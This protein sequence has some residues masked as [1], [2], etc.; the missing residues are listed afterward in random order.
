M[1]LA[2]GTARPN[3]PVSVPVV[4]TVKADVEVDMSDNWQES[5]DRMEESERRYRDI[6]EHRQLEAESLVE[7]A[8][9][10]TA[11]TD[12]E[13]MREALE[14]LRTIAQRADSIEEL[15]LRG[16][17]FSLNHLAAVRPAITKLEERLLKE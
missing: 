2:A 8:R 15:G 11:M 16:G 9:E 1:A 6:G 17:W 13:L 12:V 5:W 10:R 14:A 4:A 3:V 7:A